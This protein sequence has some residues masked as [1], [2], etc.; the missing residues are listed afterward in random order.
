[1]QLEVTSVSSRGQVVIPNQIRQSL[2]LKSGS[3]LIVIQNG[4]NILL[5]PVE[6][7]KKEQFYQLVKL[8]EKVQKELGLSREDI[9]KSIKK[10]RKRNARRR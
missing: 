8:G 5:K 7:P 10:V 1:M 9:E 6:L 4:R 2:K 3:K